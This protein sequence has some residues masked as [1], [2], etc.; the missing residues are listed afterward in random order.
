MKYTKGQSTV[1][2]LILVG[3]TGMFAAAW[4]ALRDQQFK[5]ARYMD[6]KMAGESVSRQLT[7]SM[8][9]GILCTCML[10]ASGLTFD[11][12]APAGTQEIEVPTIRAGC[13]A[14]SPVLVAVGQKFPGGMKVRRIALSDLRPDGAAPTASWI[15]EW[16]IHWEAEGTAQLAPTRLQQRV[17]LTAPSGTV[18][19]LSCAPQGRSPRLIDDCPSGWVR[20][21]PANAVG[22]FCIDRV[23]RSPKT[24]QE[25]IDDCASFQTSSN[26][27]AHLCNNSEWF[28]AC[29]R[30][31][32]QVVGM[33]NG[34]VEWNTEFAGS[35][36][37][38]VAS[39]RDGRCDL[40]ERRLRASATSY[41][42]C[43]P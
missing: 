15:G 39:G 27:T 34:N 6:Q 30:H 7:L 26:G 18:S 22:T 23:E 4:S 11:A 35:G 20:I 33:L 9:D 14:N 16:R 5:A 12:S 29:D 40:Q 3:L 36:D 2:V 10:G 25:A 28:M 19:V 1:L 37:R 43:Y 41:R 17:L 32:S 8:Q 21:G 13:D 24:Q 38:V 31:A 42:C